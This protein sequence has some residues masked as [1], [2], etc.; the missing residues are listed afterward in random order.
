MKLNDE[1]VKNNPDVIKYLMNLTNTINE[2]NMD[3]EEAA[4]D[5]TGGSGRG[6]GK[7]YDNNN[8]RQRYVQLA[9]C[10]KKAIPK[11]N[12][13]LFKKAPSF[14]VM[15]K[16]FKLRDIKINTADKAKNIESAVKNAII[17][18]QERSDPKIIQDEEAEYD[19][20]GATDGDNLPT[21][22]TQTNNN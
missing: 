11:L 2:S 9:I 22:T 15:N 14:T 4:D 16:N 17:D 13:N 12:V 19:P 7:D 8:N 18:V 1:V 10:N 20:V 5:G 3:A 6:G 21:G